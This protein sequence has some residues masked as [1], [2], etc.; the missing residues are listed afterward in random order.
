VFALAEAG[1]Q[2]GELDQV[3]DAQRRA[4]FPEDHLG[5]RSDQLGPLQGNGT[6]RVPVDREQ[7]SPPRGVAALAD[8]RELLSAV[9]MEGVRDPDKT[10]CRN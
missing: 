2:S 10:R 4:R 1:D 9:R 5:I 6:H 8:A 7:E 3:P